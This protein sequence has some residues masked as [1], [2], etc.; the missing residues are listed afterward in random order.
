M[1]RKYTFNIIIISI[2]LFYFIANISIKNLDN[3]I[4]N[5]NYETMNI[6]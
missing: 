1:N 3:Y 4:D 2:L 5:E 6:T